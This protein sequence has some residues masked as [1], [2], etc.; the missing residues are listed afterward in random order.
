MSKGSPVVTLRVPEEELARLDAAILACNSR[1]K[2]TP[3]S[4]TDFIM[5]AVREKLAKMARSRSSRK[6]KAQ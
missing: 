3:W 1:R 6:R 2:G 4:R 5:A